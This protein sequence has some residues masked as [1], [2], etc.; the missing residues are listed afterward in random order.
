M[1]HAVI[2]AHGQPSDP[3]PAEAALVAFAREVDELCQRVSVSSATLAAPQALENCLDG[4]TSDTVIYPL[5]MARGWFVT[6]ALP[7]RIGQ[8]SVTILDPMG[9][10][11]ELPAL[12]TAAI[13]QELTN[14]VWS[15]ADT[16]LVIA[17]HGS[18]RSANPAIVAKGFAEN[19]G[20]LSAF[21]SIRTGFVE[22]TPSIADAATGCGGKALCLPF[23]ACTGG[24]VLED[25]PE[26][27]ARASFHGHVMPVIS[28]LPQVKRHIAAMLDTL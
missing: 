4:L 18:G 2:V 25:V 23:F 17:A 7:K 24:H 10:D 5:F 16:D 28:E 20:R 27:L 13:H 1:T 21:N 14:R 9:I 3:A 12:I 11:P 8:R 26:E 22:Q 19:L 6:S 15:A